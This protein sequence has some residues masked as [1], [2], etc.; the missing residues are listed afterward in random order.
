MKAI[1]ADPKSIQDLFRAK[2]YVI[3]PFQRPYTWD[4]ATCSKLWEDIVGFYERWK[5]SDHQRDE[6]YFLGTII[7]YPYKQL[8]ITRNSDI[9]E[10]LGVID[11]Q[12]RLTTLILLMAALACHNKGYKA[13]N[14]IIRVVDSSQDTATDELRL[15]TMVLEDSPKSLDDIVMS[16]TQ[17]SITREKICKKDASRRNNFIL[18][19]DKINEWYIQN[20]CDG[21]RLND[22][23]GLLLKNVVVLPIHCDSEDDAFQIFE[24]VN[25]R[26]KPLAE[27]DIFKSN[28]LQQLG[29]G[30]NGHLNDKQN[31]F[32]ENWKKWC[33]SKVEDFLFRALMRIKNG[34]EGN[35][36]TTDIAIKEYFLKAHQEYFANP[37]SLISD[38]EKLYAI[39]QWSQPDEIN[40]LWRILECYPNEAWKWPLIAYL[41]RHGLFA[42]DYTFSLSPERIPDFTDKC[43]K[44]VKYF[45]G[46]N[47]AG[48]GSLNAVKGDSYKECARV[49]LPDEPR[50]AGEL[51]L[52]DEERGLLADW[53]GNLGEESCYRAG[54]QMGMGIVMLCSYLL[55]PDKTQMYSRF[56]DVGKIE[57]EH[58]CPKNWSNVD[59]WTEEEHS[60]LVNTIGNLI[61]L[62]KSI[63]IQVSNSCFEKKR[64]GISLRGRGTVP[65]AKSLSPEAQELASMSA[66]RDW[67]PEDV[68]M[69]TNRKIVALKEFFL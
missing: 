20:G 55:H 35:I 60:R 38:L 42:E 29:V 4:E 24:V 15:V 21:E 36:D 25:N 34:Q 53:I 58:I 44:M 1:S 40:V 2:Q 41:Y 12:Q 27:A 9:S 10:V 28:I 64:T 17:G 30:N 22:L 18:F 49:F 43:R 33:G 39:T 56:V 59:G 32:L 14:K 68:T 5:V 48:H 54:F 3:P 8:S 47:F 13:L 69:R 67:L 16:P 37:D 66:K 57:V 50:F 31:R 11:G 19:R 7:V 26:G 52:T 23:T 62:E 63:N 61:P 46:K 51:E 6:K 65:Y 45:F